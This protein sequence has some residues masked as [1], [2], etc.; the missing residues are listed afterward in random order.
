[1]R[2]KHH[3]AII[4]VLIV[5]AGLTPVAQAAPPVDEKGA[6]QVKAL[7]EKILQQQKSDMQDDGGQLILDGDMLVEP[8]SGYY[9]VTLP[10]VSAIF[11]D[12]GRLDVGIVALNVMPTDDPDQWK[13]T[14][15][16]PSPITFHAAGTK[17][18]IAL[19]AGE[20]YFAGVWHEKFEN[21]TKLKAQYKNVAIRSGDRTLDITIPQLEAVYDLVESPSHEWSGPMRVTVRGLKGTVP[22]GMQADIGSAEAV[23]TLYDYSTVTAASYRDNMRALK[24]SYKAGDSSASGQHITGIYNMVADVIGKVW[25]GFGMDVALTDLRLSQPASKQHPPKSVTLRKGAFFVGMNDF[26]SG[27]VTLRLKGG[28][29]GLSISPVPA[30]FGTTPTMFD[31]D[32]SIRKLP[33]ADIAT[34]GRGAVENTVHAPQ[35]ARL[36][37]LQTLLN[38]PGLMTKAGTTLDIAKLTGGNAEYQVDANGSLQADLAAL[39]GGTGKGHMKVSGLEKI[40]AATEKELKRPGLTAEEKAGIETTLARLAALQVAG[41]QGKDEKGVPARLYDFELTKEGKILVNGTDMSLL[42]PQAAKPAAPS[43]PPVPPKK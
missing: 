2:L 8:A 16:L 37:A 11:E 7:F 40:I 28:Y 6:V 5:L 1:M 22:G 10:P 19:T 4:F 17:E 27:S 14:L 20:Q 18:T 23:V 3:I 43:A 25:N 29:D 21:F 32:A 36:V 38:I 9:A 13:M 12:G 33:Y 26:R 34:L 24:E 15:A 30:D 41:Q 39:M 35:M 42:M 31:F